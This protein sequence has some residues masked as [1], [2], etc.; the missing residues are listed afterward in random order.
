MLKLEKIAERQGVKN[1]L[2]RTKP[3][4]RALG[5]TT[6]MNLKKLKRAT[7]KNKKN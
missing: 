2:F 5:K 4:K 1:K 6:S 3:H 7:A